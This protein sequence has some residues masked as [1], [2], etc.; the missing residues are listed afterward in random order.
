MTPKQRYILVITMVAGF[1]APFMSNALSLAITS[2]SS[3][4]SCGATTSTWVINIYTLCTAAFSLPFGHLADR[5]GR[6]P[7]L[8]AGTALFAA[9]SL[10]SMFAPNVYVLIVARAGMS[11]SASAFLAAT[12]PTMLTYFPASQRGRTLGT[13]VVATYLGIALGP[14]LGGWI[15]AFAGWRYIFLAGVVCGAVS[16]GLAVRHVEDDRISQHGSIDRF[17]MV[18]FSVAL[19]LMMLGLSEFGSHLWARIALGAGMAALIVFVIHETHVE[20]PV[21]QVRLFA[22]SRAYGL[23]NLASLLSFGAS[24]C[25]I[26]TMA[27]YL[28]NVRGMDSSLAGLLLMSIPTMQVLFSRYAGKLS[29]RVPAQRIA[30]CGALVSTASF[31]VLVAAP[32]DAPLWVLLIGM[33]LSGLG[34]AFFS[35]PNN[36]AILSCVDHSHYSEANSTISTMRGVGQSLSIAMVS[37]V[38]SFTIGNTVITHTDPAQLVASMH[39]IFSIALGVSVLA[40]LASLASGLERKE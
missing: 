5:F 12:I 16:C 9:F 25:V 17:G 38:F 37:L 7:F 11:I 32:P 29:D 27:L 35:T 36:N 30:T 20:S 6:K 33:V 3:D 23:S 21:V 26:Y 2:I 34:N 22:K 40:V 28:E 39:L 24:F 1:M 15:T 10:M 19:A 14:S 8:F 18:C 31:I 4:F 13:A